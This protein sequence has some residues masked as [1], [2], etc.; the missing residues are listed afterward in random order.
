MSGPGE[1]R[2]ASRRDAPSGSGASRLPRLGRARDWLIG[3]TLLIGLGIAVEHRVGLRALIAP[4]Q[5]LSVPLLVSAFALTAASYVLRGLRVYEYF[6]P[7]VVGRFTAVLRLSMLHNTANN[8]LPMRIGEVVFPWLMHR[9]FGHGFLASGASLLWIRI[10]DLHCLVLAAL[11]VLWLRLP[12]WWWPV[13]GALWL[14][15]VPLGLA[16]RRSGW[17]S[18]LPAGRLRHVLLFLLDAAPRDTPL[19]Y[20]LYLWTLLSWSA[21]LFAFALVLGHFVDAAL[22]QRLAGVLGAE[23][24]SVLPFHGIA[25]A[26]S[27][28]LTGM[29]A[30]V[31]LGVGVGAALA[32]TVS[33]H[34]FLLG[35]T[36]ILGALALLLPRGKTAAGFQSGGRS[37]ASL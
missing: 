22:W 29:A 34:L 23:L 5:T 24:S 35:S 19:L 25:G 8:L 14:A 4:W 9:Y 31:P 6:G 32:G 10:M 36:L 21:K 33:L 16:V 11:V 7:L 17:V 15:L 13:L 28:E 27:Y 2:G 30:M 12:G 26:G 3:L 18:R 1:S 20:R 37:G